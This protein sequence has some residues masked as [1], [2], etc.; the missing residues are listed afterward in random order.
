MSKPVLIFF[1]LCCTVSL[2]SGAENAWVSV[3]WP[4][5]EGRS[6]EAAVE[7]WP[8]AETPLTVSLKS[9]DEG[10]LVVPATVT[11]PAQMTSAPITITAP[12]N[13][14]RDGTRVV[15]VST[16]G[17]GV[18]PVENSVTIRDNEVVS[19]R[20]NPMTDIM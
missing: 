7:R 3:T 11:I 19:Y 17:A 1:A 5:Q 2:A 12:D 6:V 15:K 8:A 14:K 13:A 16:S 4:L 10:N 9:S 20:L 18:G